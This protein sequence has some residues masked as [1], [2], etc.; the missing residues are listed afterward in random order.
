MAK[1]YPAMLN[2]RGRLAIVIGG[3]RVA[4]EKAAGLASSGARVRVLSPTFCDELLTL[5]EQQQVTLQ[6]KMYDYG[7]LAGAFVVVAALNPYTEPQLV[8]AVWSETQERNQLV[9]IVDVPEYCSFILP[10]I[11]RREPLTIAVSTE[12]ASPGLAKRIRHS[13]EERFP[14]AY[15]T[16]LRLASVARVHLRKHNV[17]YDRRDEFFGDFYESDILALLIK[18]DIPCATTRTAELLRAYDVNVSDY[19][20]KT[21]LEEELAHVNHS[22]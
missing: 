18:N 5:A 4:A 2:L 11:L 13:L 15:G 14:Q 16:Y 22:A 19:T 8:Q 1:Y 9:N 20:L 6:Q 10:S 21:E 3:D 17:P 12:G 7:D